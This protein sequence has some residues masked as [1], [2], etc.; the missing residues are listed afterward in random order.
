MEVDQL[1]LVQVHHKPRA[2][3]W[4]VHHLELKEMEEE[5]AAEGDMLHI[6]TQ[7]VPAVAQ[8]VILEMVETAHIKIVIMVVNLEQVE[9]HQVVLLF[10]QVAVA[11][12]VSAF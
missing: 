10:L 8:V 6:I 5:L 3:V 11:A 4:K 9:E 1:H 12:E 7:V 2:M